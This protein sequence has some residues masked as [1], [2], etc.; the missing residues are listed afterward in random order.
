MNSDE[1]LKHDEQL[2]KFAF[3]FNICFADKVLEILEKQN[4][5]LENISKRLSALEESFERYPL[6]GRKG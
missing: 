1:A 6:Q 3:N 4:Q 5:E 2:K